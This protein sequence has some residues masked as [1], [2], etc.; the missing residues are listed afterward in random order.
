[1]FWETLSS[2]LPQRP[3]SLWPHP[4][5]LNH[6]MVP[7]GSS[8]SYMAHWRFKK[9]TSS[10]SCKV[11][12]DIWLPGSNNSSRVWRAVTLLITIT[13][14]S[15]VERTVPITWAEQDIHS[16]FFFSVCLDLTSGWICKNILRILFHPMT[17]LIALGLRS[18]LALE[19]LLLSLS[20][21]GET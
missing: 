5:L 14:W 10:S 1:M 2:C 9:Q 3:G 7:F 13:N 11:V 18:T 19:R 12:T 6:C 15:K 20:D 16:S 8:C 4:K 21:I 17:E